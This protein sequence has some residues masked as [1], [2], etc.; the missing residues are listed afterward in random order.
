MEEVSCWGFE[1]LE[2]RSPQELLITAW[3]EENVRR[4]VQDDP[5]VTEDGISFNLKQVTEKGGGEL[6]LGISKYWN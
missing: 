2:G 6:V 1:N 4:V 3:M 5:G